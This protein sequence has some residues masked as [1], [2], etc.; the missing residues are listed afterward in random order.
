MAT[1]QVT[2]PFGNFNFL[3]EIDGITRAAFQEVSGFD[4]TIDVIEHREGGENTTPRKLPGMT[5][6]SNLTLKWGITD[7]VDL[8]TWHRQ[9]VQGQIERRNGSIVLLDRA[10]QEVARWN[11]F[12]AWPTKYDGP[13][14]NAEGND[15]AIET[16]ELAH[17]G[18][19]R[20]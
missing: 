1:G 8:Y 7:D 17:E 3:V 9:I 13:D 15:V 6:Y 12:R 5:K 10:G 2:D 20:V 16:L 18:V 14:L 4:S 11:F 19:E